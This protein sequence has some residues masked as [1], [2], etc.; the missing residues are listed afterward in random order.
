ML[1]MRTQLQIKN[2]IEAGKLI[3]ISPFRKE[4]RK[5]T[6]HKHHNYFEIIFLTKGMG[7]HYID[8]RNYP[9]EPPIM[10]FIRKEQV[11]YWEITREPEGFVLILK[12]AFLEASLD[13]EL[14]F[15]LTEISSQ[16]G[17]KIED[18]ETISMILKLMVDEGRNA[19]SFHVLEG[20]LKAL[21][22]KV[23]EVAK[24]VINKTIARTDIYQ[25]YLE[26]LGREGTGKNNVAHYARLLNTSPQ[27]LNAIC[28]RTT[29]QSAAEVLAEFIISESKRL[30]LYTD[31]T[32]SGI[33]YELDF[34]DP[35]HFVKYFKRFTH[36]TPQAFRL[37]ES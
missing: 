37:R 33:A 19:N 2:K 24:P 26:L 30:L 28:R 21:L 23:L 22:S 3:Q 36:L 35:S 10:Y 29:N 4:V 5:T 18:Y 15:L 25:S 16:S 1:N 34:K 9:I 20:L 12:K 6:P 31:K 27:N 8:M 7:S 14:R 17:L 32:V 13:K 11:H